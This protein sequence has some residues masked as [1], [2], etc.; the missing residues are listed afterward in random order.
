MAKTIAL[1]IKIQTQ[2]GE[3]VVKN[4][5]ELE[6]EIESLSNELKGLDFGSEAFE[7]ASKDL[8]TL[9]AGLRD[10]EKTVE[11]LDKE[12]S[13]QAFGAAING[14]TG[15]FLIASSAARTFG[16]EAE[17]V[18]EIQKAEQ[19]ALEAVNIAL[20][21]QALAEAFIQ[22]EKIKTLALRARDIIATNLE[23]VS[24]TAY[25]LAVGASTGALKAFRIALATTGVGALIV[26]IGYLISKLFEYN[27]A[28]EE[29][30]EETKQLSEYQLE[31]VQSTQK[32]LASIDRLTTILDDNNASLKVKEKAYKELQKVVPDLV[33]LTLE[34][35]QATGVLNT[36]VERQIELIKL[37]AEARAIE[38][39]LTEQAKLQI[40]QE[41]QEAQQKLLTDAL[42]ETNSRY[43][44]ATQILKGMG[45]ATMEQALA[46][47]DAR[48]AMYESNQETDKSITLEDRLLELQK[49]ILELQGDQTDQ[50]NANNKAKE[51][52]NRLDKEYEASLQKLSKAIS[53]V[54]S[55]FKNLDFSEEASVEILGKANELLQ[56]Q[57]DLLNERAGFFKTQIGVNDDYTESLNRLVGGI[58]VP[59]DT[60]EGL[61]DIQDE[62]KNLLQEV[63]ELGKG[64]DK[65]SQEVAQGI[66]RNLGNAGDEVEY[67]LKRLPETSE[68]F[69]K[70]NDEQKSVLVDF[71]KQTQTID[72][73]LDSFNKGVQDYNEGL[74]DATGAQE[75]ALGLNLDQF[76][77]IEKYN[78]ALDSRLDNFK[79]EQDIQQELSEEISQRIFDG[80]VLAEL[81]EDQLTVVQGI[82][83]AIFEQAKFY[84]EVLDVNKDLEKVTQDIGANIAE[85]S[86]KLSDSEFLTLFEKIKNDAETNLPALKKFFAELSTDASNLTQEQ[87]DNIN[88]YLSEFT[89]GLENSWDDMDW[90]EKVG[91]IVAV[92]S[93]L[94][95]RIQSIAQASISL[96][97]ERLAEYEKQTL[98]IIGDESEA[99][100]QKQLEFQKKINKQRFELE[101]K[102][103][104]QELNFA[105][106]SSIA[107]GAQAV[108]NALALPIP[109][110]GPQIVAGLYAG[111]T[112]VELAV[113]NSQKQ[114]VQGQQFVARRGGLVTGPSHEYGGV[115]AQGG[116]VLEG[117]EFI[118][119]QAASTQ[120]ADI[121]SSINTSTGGRGMGVDDSA[122]VQEIRK[123]NQKPI[124]TFVLYQDIQDTNKI[125]SR[126]EEISRL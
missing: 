95:S 91:Q 62:F 61:I 82:S 5:N 80:K 43:E 45:A 78:N 87:L 41:Q 23:T 88:T 108:I 64:F 118:V 100:R 107:A 38:E 51:E 121:L 52:R 42:V 58:V 94:T 81:N 114:F 116:L 40:A 63:I 75:R 14:V 60:K 111:L 67:Y 101:K 36:A 124:K 83:D 59:E 85:Q 47:V 12:Q 69:K 98:A 120:Y 54:A 57:T 76:V 10:V 86:Q 46:Q 1:N 97:L 89:A 77:L 32:E 104:V 33:G 53:N 19:A 7:K 79:T 102:A 30:V 55:Q 96:E 56:E 73:L 66:I 106:A 109:P 126:L 13:I 6:K 8:G 92:I 105:L 34:E 24:Q 74:K 71:L 70:L 26:G 119:N 31:A 11:G 37:R 112:A 117:G 35:A 50:T 84:K 25:T 68:V 65:N 113:I 72:G 44:E 110:P 39:Y 125:N 20:G 115:A 15:A 49:K 99:A 21:V 122:L 28:T 3:K 18:E 4:I 2:G 29:A 9:K 93:D 90:D 22:R 27:D 103:R 17:T 48:R 123:Q 16:A